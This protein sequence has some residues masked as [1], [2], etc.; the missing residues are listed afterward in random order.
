MIVAVEDVLSETVVR[1]LVAAIRPDQTIS[2]VMRKNGRG[3]L[4]SR[5]R[6]L[7]RTAYSVPVLIVADLDRPI[8]CPADLIE[9]WLSGP[10]APGLLFRVAVMEIESWI[11][12]DRDSFADFLAVPA[13]RIPPNTDEI[14]HPKEFI[15]SLAR[16]SR[17]KDIRVD[18]VPTPGATAAVGPAFNHRVGTFVSSSWNV[19]KAAH[20]SPS[21]R[22]AISS[23][24]VAFT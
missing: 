21:L 22:R 19:Q 14:M 2:V 6:D 17:S 20:A 11:L 24:A 15:V 8:P 10:A 16:K 18:L 1:R 23:L 4:Q 5:A 13:H 9:E 7:N 3:Y 12:A